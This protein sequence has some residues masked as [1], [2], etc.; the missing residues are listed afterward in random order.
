MDGVLA[1]F[2]AAKIK[3]GYDKLS[4][5]DMWKAIHGNH[6]TWFRDLPL[7]KDA[8]KL[9][10]CMMGYSDCSLVVLTAVGRTESMKVAIQKTEWIREWI[11]SEA[12]II[13]CRRKHKADWA[14]EDSLLIDDHEEN[15]EAFRAR[16][17]KAILYKGFDDCIA[18]YKD[19]IQ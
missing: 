13:P 17:G 11:D 9:Y 5:D 12:V 8:D 2:D 10:W 7:M 14:T 6:P 15:C 1:D 16:G 18:R 3:H 19:I 4:E